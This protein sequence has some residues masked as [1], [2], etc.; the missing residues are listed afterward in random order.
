MLHSA[1]DKCNVKHWCDK[2][3]VK[4]YL[5][6]HMYWDKSNVTNVLWNM[7]LDKCNVTKVMCQM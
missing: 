7:Y 6:W 2:C 3:N 5:L 4:N 1:C